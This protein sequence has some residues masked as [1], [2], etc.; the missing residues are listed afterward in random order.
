M[1][2]TELRFESVQVTL[3]DWG[4]VG[5]GSRGAH[6]LELAMLR[7]YL[8]RSR[9]IEP[10]IASSFRRPAFVVGID[11]AEEKANGHASR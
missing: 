3:H 2:V 9:D 8:V 5:I 6:A 10:T 4:Q 7:Q 11:E 1:L